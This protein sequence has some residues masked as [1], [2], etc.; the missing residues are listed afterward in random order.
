MTPALF[1]KEPND[2][3]EL[4]HSWRFVVR[5]KAWEVLVC[6]YCIS[7]F[8]AWSFRIPAETFQ[9]PDWRN[10]W[11]DGHLSQFLDGNA[12]MPH[13]IQRSIVE[14]HFGDIIWMNLHHE[15]PLVTEFLP[16][17]QV[18]W[19]GKSQNILVYPG[20]P[21]TT[22]CPL[23]VGN[24]LLAG[25]TG[26]SLARASYGSRKRAYQLL[27]VSGCSPVKPGYPP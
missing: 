24:P 10:L 3:A 26:N 27:A 21:K 16:T 17:N 22:L 13:Q 1:W 7:F 9:H 11:A 2:S 20:S 19:I 18:T 14:F 5:W 12:A 8:G 23:V 15:I 25:F 6:M 4:V